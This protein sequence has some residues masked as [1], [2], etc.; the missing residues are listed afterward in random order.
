MTAAPPLAPDGLA[1]LSDEL[2]EGR[3]TAEALCRDALDRLAV[4]EPK[5][6][7]FTHLDPERALGHA[8][9]LDALRRSGAN[10][11]PL[12]GIPVAIKDL[13]TVDG[14]PTTGGSRLDIRD[15]VPPQGPFVKGLLAGGCVPLG[16]TRTTEFALGGFNLNRPPPWNPCDMT[17]RRMTGGSSHG[18]AVAVAAG[19]AGFAVGSDTGGSVRWP[20]AL[21][22][23]VGY[24][25]SPTHWPLDGVLPLSPEMDSIGIFT[26][27]AEDAAFVEAALNSRALG[28]P[29]PV[30]TLRLALPTEHF[31]DNLEAPVAACFAA[32]VERLRD[33][34]ARFVELPAPEARWIDD[35]FGHLV[36]ADLLAFL[37][38]ERVERDLALMDAVAAARLEGGAG[39]R[40]DDYVRMLALRRRAERAMAERSRGIDAW[41]TPTLPMLPHPVSEYRTVAEVAAWNRLA[42]QNTRPANLCGQCG[43]SLPIQHLGADLPV[44][45]QLTAGGGQDARLLDVARAIEQLLDPG[46][47]PGA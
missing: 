27:S 41:I 37:G 46:P 18:S 42:T 32:A 45:L 28:A 16:K 5:L 9:A 35:I 8:R 4:M 34:G 43:I 19:L 21:C 36:P 15:L 17:Q 24:K 39:L 20:A 30:D 6:E 13:F 2:R 44:G 26:R 12:M 10:L 1:A 23:V 14:M 25:A 38:R 11:G 7:A 29:P 3:L 33:A 47:A 22:G 40:A 31:L